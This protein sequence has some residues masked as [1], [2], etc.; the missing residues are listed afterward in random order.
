MPA[1]ALNLKSGSLTFFAK[2]RKVKADESDDLEKEKEKE[3]GKTDGEIDENDPQNQDAEDDPE[4]V[5]NDADRSDEADKTSETEEQEVSGDADPDDTKT[6]LDMSIY[7]EIGATE[8]DPDETS[9]AFAKMLA[10]AGDI[11]EV[12]LSINSGGGDVF[13]AIAIVNQ[14]RAKGAK[15]RAYVD[16]LAASAASVIAVSADETVM[17][18]GS[19]LMIHNAWSM[20]VGDKDTMKAAATQ[21][22]KIDGTIAKLYSEESD[23]SPED[24]AKLMDDETWMTDEEAVEMGFADRVEGKV[25]A[26]RVNNKLV[27]NS[28]AFD[29]SKF[30]SKPKNFEAL[31][32]ARSV[33]APKKLDAKQPIKLVTVTKPVMDEKQLKAKFNEGVVA[34]RQRNADLDELLAP[35]TEEL[36]TQ[37]RADGRTKAQVMT[38]AF[39]LMRSA[40]LPPGSAYLAKRSKETEIIGRVNTSN[41]AIV[42]PTKESRDRDEREALA[43]LIAGPNQKKK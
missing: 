43:N 31:P 18:A 29:L 27:Y 24:V 36:I 9:K 32:K 3:D 12:N 16:G 39:E 30:K 11:D 19:M 23:K 8:E 13:S 42:T 22:E 25:K 34:E 10:D 2:V 26:E 6:I 21:L 35:E 14:L 17:R 1:K 33:K 38:E 41:P 20:A 4:K 37:A 28:I 7:G 15:V 5:D 40:K